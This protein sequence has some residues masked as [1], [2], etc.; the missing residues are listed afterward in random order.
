LPATAVRPWRFAAA[1]IHG[2]SHL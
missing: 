1:P 2:W